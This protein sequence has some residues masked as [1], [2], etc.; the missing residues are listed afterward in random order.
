LKHINTEFVE[1]ESL[2]IINMMVKVSSRT[3]PTNTQCISNPK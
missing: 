3:T 2:P 1:F